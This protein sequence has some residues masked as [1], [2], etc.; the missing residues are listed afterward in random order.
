MEKKRVKRVGQIKIIEDG[1]VRMSGKG[2]Q[3]KD[4]NLPIDRVD[5]E[6]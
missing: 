5:A 6:E 1:P 2:D 3:S 4:S